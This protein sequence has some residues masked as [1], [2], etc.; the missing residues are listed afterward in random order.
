MLVNCA[1]VFKRPRELTA[2]G[3]SLCSLLTISAPFLLTN[4]LLDRIRASAPARIVNVTV[5]SRTKIDFE[6][7]QGSVRFPSLRAFGATETANLLFTFELADRL[8]GAG[9]TANAVHPSS[10]A[11]R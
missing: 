4:L 5:P 9:L 8:I 1:A 3:T 2:E 6:G 7:V 11:R 10:H